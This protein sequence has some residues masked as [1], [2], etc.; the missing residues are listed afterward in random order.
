MMMMMM[1]MMVMMMM[2]LIII[3]IIIILYSK[4]HSHECH[5]DILKAIYCNLF[6]LHHHRHYDQ[7]VLHYDNW[8]TPWYL[9]DPRAI[10]FQLFLI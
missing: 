6:F 2:M 9:Y 4:I 1:M 3:I 5:A 8:E 7:K 10:R